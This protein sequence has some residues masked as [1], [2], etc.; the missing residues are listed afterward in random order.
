MQKI[1]LQSTYNTKASGARPR[2]PDPHAIVD[3]YCALM[4]LISR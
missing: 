1:A 2:A 3:L 4:H